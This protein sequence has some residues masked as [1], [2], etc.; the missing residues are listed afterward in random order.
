MIRRHTYNSSGATGPKHV[1]YDDDYTGSVLVGI[2]SPHYSFLD[3]GTVSRQMIEERQRGYCLTGNVTC[4]DCN[5][6]PRQAD[7]IRCIV[8]EWRHTQRVS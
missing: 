5:D 8:C 4:F 1:S 7:N 6:S 3:V 2:G